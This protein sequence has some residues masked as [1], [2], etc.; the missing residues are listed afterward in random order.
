MKRLFLLR[1]AKSSWTDES[2]SDF[3]R[4][5]DDRGERAAAALAVYGRQIGLAPDRAIVSPAARTRATW[6][7]LAAEGVVAGAVDYEDRVYGAAPGA[8][9][10]L[11]GRLP[12]EAAEALIVG[13]N[14]GLEALAL[15]LAADDDPLRAEI[16]QKFPTGAFVGFALDLD[17]WGDL[18]AGRARIALYVTP[19]QLV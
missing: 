2:L 4:P 15:W 5:L 7:R 12:A 1:H 11:L 10:Q 18:A 17:D 3:D 19:K 9:A 13:H 16:A 14:P 8:L 6:A